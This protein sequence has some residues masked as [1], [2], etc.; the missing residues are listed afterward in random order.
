[1]M[2]VMLNMTNDVQKQHNPFYTI[3][4]AKCDMI[5][6][7]LTQQIAFGS[8]LRYRHRW[9]SWKISCTRWWHRWKAPPE[10]FRSKYS[11]CFSVAVCCWGS[12]KRQA[13]V[14]LYDSGGKLSY[15]TL[16]VSLFVSRIC[17][18]L[19]WYFIWSHGY[20][21]DVGWW[22]RLFYISWCASVENM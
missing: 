19:V 10:K 6:A 1:M 5:A 8:Y 17:A 13:L 14:R 20:A 22:W 11:E 15:C 2:H 12:G 3:N 9:I 18:P 21:S 16:S 4:A 7:F